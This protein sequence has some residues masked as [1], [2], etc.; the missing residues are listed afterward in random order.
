MFAQLFHK[1]MKHVGPVRKNLGTRTIFNLLG[2]LSNPAN[3]KKQLLGVFDKKWLKIHAKVLQKLGSRHVLVVH[4]LDGLDE[5]SLSSETFINELKNNKII[6]YIFKPQ[7]IGY[8]M[9]NIEQIR[10]GDADYNAKEIINM[11]EG[12]NK[13]F[14][15][16]VE[17]N[18]GAA[19]YLSGQAKNIKEGTEISK[20]VINNGITKSYLK[21]LINYPSL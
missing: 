21:S 20:K 8:S 14:Q 16:I 13:A 18:A 11:L 6:E 10:G 5:I 1:T 7:D 4:S 2:P 19:I 9:I 12:K 17:L 3:A 15:E